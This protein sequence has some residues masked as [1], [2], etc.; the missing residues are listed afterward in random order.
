MGLFAAGDG[1][2]RLRAA[3]RLTRPL[4]RPL[5]PPPRSWAH[6]STSAYADRVKIMRNATWPD[7]MIS[8]QAIL[9]CDQEAGTC[10]GGDDS[11]VYARFHE[12]G[13]PELTCMNYQAQDFACSPLNYCRT[14]SPSGGCTAVQNYTVWRASQYGPVSG[15]AAMMAEIY[16]RGP[17]SCGIDASYIEDYTGGV[18]TQTP[19]DWSIDHI[20]SLAGWGVAEVD[21]QEIPYWVLR[22]SWGTYWG[23]HGW[24]RIIRG[25]NALGL[26]SQ[27]NWVVP[28]LAPGY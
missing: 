19:A 24:M 17:I 22:N 20:I 3:P 7:V 14:C 4:Y 21:G 12:K 2:Q 11:A 28:T 10:D 25:K 6:G 9:N 26:E 18:F 13:L 1:L 27:C 15:E 16:A 5:S 23:E 8:V